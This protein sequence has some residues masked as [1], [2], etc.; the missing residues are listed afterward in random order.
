MPLSEKEK[1]DLTAAA[2][3]LPIPPIQG[4]RLDMAQAARMQV[5]DSI[6]GIVTLD[7]PDGAPAAD[8]VEKLVAEAAAL[9]PVAPPK[10][11]DPGQNPKKH[12]RS[13]GQQA[14][15]AER[16]AAAEPEAK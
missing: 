11:F 5:I 8:P 6:A 14:H 2:L 13:R 16:I 12:K 4:D 7:R 9:P 15:V 3:R 10:R 1:Q